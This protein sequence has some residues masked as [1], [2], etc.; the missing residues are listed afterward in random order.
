MLEGKRERIS[1]LLR[2][3]L[4]HYGEGR[5]A[6]AVRAWNE[7]LFLDPFHAEANDYLASAGANAR[8]AARPATAPAGGEGDPVPEALRLL[9]AGELEPALALLEAASR[10]DAGRLEIQGYLELA[11]GRLVE[12]YRG[13]V[14]GLA[15]V[16][17]LQLGAGDVLRFNLPATAGFLLSLVDGHTTVEDLISLSGLDTFETLRVLAGLIDAGILRSPA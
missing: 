7:V 16:P 9:R 1:R 4:D 17:A 13:R 2:E 14:G 11:R 8:A 10:R 6:E 15:A 12:R 5:N 3:G